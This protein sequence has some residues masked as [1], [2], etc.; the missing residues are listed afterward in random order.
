MTVQL[1]PGS[2]GI[3]EIL[4]WIW[5]LT[6]WLEEVRQAVCDVHCHAQILAIVQALKQIVARL[7]VLRYEDVFPFS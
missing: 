6:L 4:L 1:N 5:A 3:H 7:S 2:P